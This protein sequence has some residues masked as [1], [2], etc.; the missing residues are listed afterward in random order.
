MLRQTDDDS[1][2]YRPWIGMNQL[3][4]GQYVWADSSEVKYTNWARGEPNGGDEA[5]VDILLQFLYNYHVI[6]GKTLHIFIIQHIT[7]CKQYIYI[8]I[9]IYCRSNVF[10]FGRWRT[11]LDNGLIMTVTASIPLSACYTEVGN[12]A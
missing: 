2:D 7:S 10:M 9:Y 6:Y 12:K 1:G 4:N 11:K 5:C 3:E 8:Y